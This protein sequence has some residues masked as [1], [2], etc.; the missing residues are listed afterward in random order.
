MR[1]LVT[2]ASGVLGGRL[3]SLLRD[4]FEVI[5]ARHR[6]APPPG[7]I[8]HGLDLLSPA[9]IESALEAVRPDAVL[10][11]AAL[12]DVDRCERDP[13]LAWRVNTLA[14]ESLARI[15]RAR[16]L[17]L[18]AI[19]TDLVFGDGPGLR[20]E[21]DPPQPLSVYGRSKLAAEQ[22]VLAESGD[23]AVARVTLVVGRGHGS[24]AS[25]SESVAWA[26]SAGQAPRLYR[27]Q[28]RTPIDPESVASGVA[29]LIAS[30]ASGVFHFA[31][32]E[33]VS[34]L[35]LGRRTARSLG[36]D[37]AEIRSVT[38]ADRPPAAPRPREVCLGHERAR[39]ELGW[40][41]RALDA[42]LGESRKAPDIIAPATP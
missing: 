29:R 15:C 31:G 3:A 21:T 26:L 22:A 10:H 7:L 40:R 18:V 38:Q 16:G 1:L 6:S 13:D 19:S 20:G 23:A 32:A 35:E 28:F 8:E 11:A 27:D 34:R 30:A 24:R 37:P 42:A 12:P 41:P 14:T 9:A 39:A 4:S 25:A 36:L 5:A 17:R 33:R 2:G